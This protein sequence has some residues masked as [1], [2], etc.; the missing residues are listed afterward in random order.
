[1]R[2]NKYMKQMTIVSKKPK[3]TA[4]TIRKAKQDGKKKTIVGMSSGSS[5]IKA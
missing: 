3:V 2:K 1:M 5:G 4:T